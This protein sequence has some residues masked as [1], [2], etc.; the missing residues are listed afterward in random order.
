MS[1]LPLSQQIAM[2]VEKRGGIEF[3]LKYSETES[4]EVLYYFFAEN[5][6]DKANIRKIKQRL[7]DKIRCHASGVTVTEEKME[8]IFQERCDQCEF[9]QQATQLVEY[10]KEAPPEPEF[11]EINEEFV[12]QIIL[13][14]FHTAK[15]GDKD[16]I[17]RAGLIEKAGKMALKLLDK[18]KVLQKS[19]S[20][21]EMMTAEMV[22][23]LMNEGI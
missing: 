1:P 23:Q 20:D 15:N 6:K 8:E 10:K 16:A 19:M 11:T 2:F 13:S 12:Q 7:L 5:R 4:L 17:E 9:K 22:A 3:W 14:L 21:E 18:K